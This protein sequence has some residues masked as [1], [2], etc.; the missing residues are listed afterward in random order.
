MNA[1]HERCEERHKEEC[2]KFFAM[3]GMQPCVRLFSIFSI[4]LKL[5]N[6]S[7]FDSTLQGNH[8]ERKI[9]KRSRKTSNN[10][11]CVL[12]GKR[13]QS[14]IHNWSFLMKL[15]KRHKN[16]SACSLSLFRLLVNRY[17]TRPT[18]PKRGTRT[19]TINNNQ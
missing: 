11:L 18:R 2:K 19:Q 4:L 9:P 17:P 3:D 12:Y 14:R 10:G 15:M 16:S 6:N 5:L 7:C 1:V 13:I 8:N